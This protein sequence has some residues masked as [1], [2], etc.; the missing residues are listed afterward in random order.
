MEQASPIPRL[1]LI[2]AQGAG[3]THNAK[4]LKF[5]QSSRC[6]SSFPKQSW[7]KPRQST[8]HFISEEGRSAPRLGATCLIILE[9]VLASQPP[10]STAS[11]QNPQ[12]EKHWKPCEPLRQNTIY[13][14]LITTGLDK[15]LPTQTSHA[16]SMPFI[17]LPRIHRVPPRRRY[18][19]TS[20]ANGM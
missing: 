1:L 7:A 8:C 20:A 17:S 16:S 3:H 5:T 12:R 10:T 2:T 19:K 6:W 9:T 14:L 18:C 4:S 13:N 11:N 15:L